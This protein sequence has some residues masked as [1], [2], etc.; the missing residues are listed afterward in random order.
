MKVEYRLKS[1]RIVPGG[2][3][4]R[5]GKPRGYRIEKLTKGSWELVRFRTDLEE[6][7]QMIKDRVF[8]GRKL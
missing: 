1:W 3:F 2:G 7:I 4:D 5:A 8:L 6:A